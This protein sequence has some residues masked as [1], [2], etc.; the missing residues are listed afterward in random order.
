[1]LPEEVKPEQLAFLT[2]SLREH[3]FSSVGFG[4]GATCFLCFVMLEGHFT[5]R[6]LILNECALWYVVIHCNR[7]QPRWWSKSHI[8]QIGTV[9]WLYYIGV[10]HVILFDFDYTLFDVEFGT[11]KVM[12]LRTQPIHNSPDQAPSEKTKVWFAARRAK[13][14]VNLPW[15]TWFTVA[16][17]RLGH[18]RA[19]A[20]EL[21]K[22]DWFVIIWVGQFLQ[23]AIWYIIAP[24]F[25]DEIGACH[26]RFCQD[27]RMYFSEYADRWI[28]VD[29]LTRISV[30][31]SLARFATILELLGCPR[32]VTQA[33]LKCC[34]TGQDPKIQSKNAAIGHWIKLRSIG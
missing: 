1:M 32:V 8:L 3:G 31:Y 2:A 30:R 21:S 28:I 15:N 19:A 14:A 34:E 7:R 11:G 12:A 16:G 18:V 22:R 5:H 20:V 10:D 26:H 23:G 4:R 27:H 29:L 25:F 9:A 17:C 6:P 24:C 13:V 33:L